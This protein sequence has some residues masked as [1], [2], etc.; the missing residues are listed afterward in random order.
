M[1]FSNPYHAY[2]QLKKK[3]KKTGSRKIVFKTTKI[4]TVKPV[5]P[6]IHELNQISHLFK[7]MYLMDLISLRVQYLKPLSN[8]I[9]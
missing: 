9:I 3:T 1:S 6:L 7:I 5:L 4:T 2:G 8:I